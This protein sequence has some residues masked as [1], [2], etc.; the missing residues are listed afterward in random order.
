MNYYSIIP[1]VQDR[2]IEKIEDDSFG[3]KDLSKLLEGLI[4]SKSNKPPFSIGLLGSWGSGKSTI[5]SLYLKSLDDDLTKNSKNVKRSDE[6]ICLTFNAWRFGGESDIKRALLRSVFLGL[7]GDEDI[8][9]SELF[10]QK[11]V[12][13]TISHSF[14]ER[15]KIRIFS[16]LEEILFR[17]VQ[18]FI[19]FSIFF[20]TIFLLDYFTKLIPDLIIKIC[21]IT[22]FT[23]LVFIV[24]IIL[25]SKDGFSIHGIGKFKL[26]N[27]PKRTAEEY[28]RLLLFEIRKFCKKNK[29]VKRLVIFVD[30]L[31]RLSSHEMIVGLDAIRT[32]MEIPQKDLPD[33]GII[34]VISCDEEKIAHALLLRDTD[35]GLPGAI[36]NNNDARRYLDRIFQ[37]R[38]DI[39]L[40]PKV[41]MRKYGKKII[42][43]NFPEINSHIENEGGNIDDVIDRLI[44]IDV[45]S[46]R[47]VIQ[48]INCFFFTWWLALNREKNIIGIDESGSLNEG[49]VTSNPTTLAIMCALHVDHPTFFSDLE[50]EPRLIEAFKKTFIDTPNSYSELPERIKHILLKYCNKL[51]LN[52]EHVS[53]SSIEVSQQYYPLK[54]FIGSLEGHHWPEN[55]LPFLQISQDPLTRKYGDKANKIKNSLVGNDYNE[56]LSELGV[57]DGKKIS[58]N[59]SEF[60]YLLLED[61][62]SETPIRKNNAYSIII[63]IIDKIPEYYNKRII[64]RISSYIVISREFRSR[65]GIQEIV[66][67]FPLFHQIDKSNLVSKLI[68]DAFSEDHF[69]LTTPNGENLIIDDVKKSSILITDIVLD[70]WKEYDLN[71]KDLK[72]VV[73]WLI[74]RNISNGTDNGYVSFDQ[75]YQWVHKSDGLLIKEL[76]TAYSRL[77]IDEIRKPDISNEIVKGLLDDVNNVFNF[78]LNKSDEVNSNIWN[79]L[80][81]LCSIRLNEVLLFCTNF[82][83]IN[84]TTG[85]ITNLNLFIIESINNIFP[86]DL[87]DEESEGNIVLSSELEKILENQYSIIKN[88]SFYLSADAI[89]SLKKFCTNCLEIDDLIKYCCRIVEILLIVDKEC[90]DE[91]VTL[92]MEK[93]YEIDND[94]LITW[95]SQN[96]STIGDNN[97]K[98][99]INAT[100]EQ[101]KAEPIL[102][103][104]ITKYN[105]FYK[106]LD[107]TV[108]ISSI[109]QNHL[110]YLM[111]KIENN[112]SKSEKIVKDLF[113]ILKI[114]PFSILPVE[115]GTMLNRI[116]IKSSSKGDLFHWI[117][118]EFLGVWPINA[119]GGINYDEIFNLCSSSIL[120]NP[121]NTNVISVLKT[122]CFFY[123]NKLISIEEAESS[124]VDSILNIWPYFQK[125]AIS[126]I[127]SDK[128]KIATS[129]FESLLDTYDSIETSDIDDISKVFS[130]IASTNSLED[131]TNNAS[132]ILEKEPI[133]NPSYPDLAFHL[134]I[135]NLPHDQ[136]SNILTSMIYHSINSDRN[137]ARIW[138]NIINKINLFNISEVMSIIES[139][140]SDNRLIKT[141]MEIISNKKDISLIFSNDH[142]LSQFSK[143]LLT[144]LINSKNREIKDQIGNWIMDLDN[145][146]NITIPILKKY[147]LTIDDQEI[148]LNLF[149]NDLKKQN[150]FKRYFG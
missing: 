56:L 150:R 99:I 21:L 3:H 72:I 121:N 10:Q 37:Y 14:I 123:K 24:S 32:F 66:H 120:N 135:E 65:V 126:I 18:I 141:Q 28:E 54:R 40:L 97:Q 42:V 88:S 52:I 17:I 90:A 43:E 109:F 149:N 22:I 143:F 5:K 107:N 147:S 31:D 138:T 108:F 122:Q 15:F 79:Q 63:K 46:P 87:F 48:L 23:V 55:L 39:P 104:I 110:T 6:I 53:S 118:S 114:I 142:E 67:I 13:K 82:A 132:I 35:A 96:F 83:L 51:N 148:I 130:Y 98:I 146:S 59:D 44:H 33:I 128:I 49:I 115:F 144:L 102:P 16:T 78:L 111:T 62:S 133:G 8:L 116:F 85:N 131:N 50:K 74:E 11:E 134:W 89:L 113:P 91:I 60:I 125:D 124:I 105:Q 57:Y 20:F 81:S 9:N 61:I 69:L 84:Q 38:I 68:E 7:G 80:V 95:L 25:N 1:F 94:I 106:N 75:L 71:P 140:F 12:E 100:E 26:T 36:S 76:N 93:S 19:I 117:L 64:E 47:N 29:N 2:E 112:I 101:L 77:V 73:K 119:L 70:F 103:N 137:A 45:S 41:D 58:S 139:I 136:I 4:E 92:M 145:G 30:D 86:T 129:Q 27:Y 34:F 127:T